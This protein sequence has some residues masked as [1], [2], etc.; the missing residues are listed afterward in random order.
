MIDKAILDEVLPVPELET[1][2]EE[3]IAE[4]KEE[5]FAITNFHSGGVFYT[6]LLIVLRIK[7]EFT[8]LLRAILN[9]MTLTHSTGAWLDIKAADYGKKRK[10]AQ[11]AQ[12]L[13]TLS[14]TNDQGEAVKIEKGHIFKTQKDINGEEL[15]FFAIE[16]AVLQK[17]SRSV[18]VLV[19]AEKEGSRYNVPEGQITRSLT[20]L[21]GIDGI[22]NGEDWI[23]REGSDTEDDEG[24]RTRALRSWSEL[25]ARS[26][27]DTF[28]NAAEAVQGVLFAHALKAVAEC[29]S[30]I[31]CGRVSEIS[32]VNVA[33]LL[34]PGQTNIVPEKADFDVEV[35]SYEEEE[36][37]SIVQNICGHVE[38]VCQAWGAK[39]CKTENRVSNAFCIPVTAPIIEKT[40]EAMR[41]IGI[42]P[43]I[44]QTLGGSDI[45]WLVENGLAAINIGVGMQ[46]VHGCKEHILF[47]DMISTTEVLLR[48]LTT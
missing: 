8:E 35:R 11:K 21:N 15:R 32:V 25:A 22:S 5:G 38:K 29:I 6:L 31:E 39:F 17:G 10:K 42:T 9:N 40:C 26:I 14:R 34:C 46:E 44:E 16:A 2:K 37:Q 1:L 43:V 18:D 33:N 20:F 36:L 13:V 47:E 19:E 12:G 41:S 4:L 30:G 24:L 45:T 7:I 23:V 27:E 3:K 48:V 28:I